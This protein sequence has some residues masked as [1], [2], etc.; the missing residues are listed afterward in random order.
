MRC[1]TPISKETRVPGVPWVA[2]RSPRRV[3]SSASWASDMASGM[4][5]FAS[6]R[7]PLFV[8]REVRFRLPR[9]VANRVLVPL[10]SELPLAGLVGLAAIEQPIDDK[11]PLRAGVPPNGEPSN[12]APGWC[13]TEGEAVTPAFGFLARRDPP[14][15]PL[16]GRVLSGR[17]CLPWRG[18]GLPRHNLGKRLRCLQHERIRGDL[19]H[20]KGPIDFGS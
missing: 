3:S 1:L 7:I 18:G 13:P 12:P 2:V 11:I 9:A 8:P 6:G 16:R 5:I 15:A 14:P 19:L 17:S 4:A 10:D 20:P